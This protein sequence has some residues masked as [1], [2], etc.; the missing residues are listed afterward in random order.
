MIY[1][2]SDAHL[3]SRVIAQHDE[4]IDRLARLL[5]QL[6]N[7]ATHIFLLGDIFDFWYEY[8][9]EPHSWQQADES[10]CLPRGKRMFLPVIKALKELTTNGVEVHFFIGNHDIWTFGDLERNTGIHLHRSP[11]T[12]KLQG[13]TVYMAHGDGIVPTG[14]MEQ[15]PPALQ[16]KIRRFMR[17]RALFHHPV[18]QHLFRLLPPAL[19]DAFGYEWARRSRLKELRRPC[20]F[21]GETNEELLLW[22][23]EHPEYDYCI[24]GHRHIELDWQLDERRR[25]LILGD[26]FRQFTY[27]AMQN[28]DIRIHHHSPDL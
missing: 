11:A 24:F 8:L 18:A 15:L 26:F 16:T 10:W 4:H 17:L 21:K 19:G 12:F 3:G 27:A 13:K 2:L 14:Y 20:P 6:A 25:V 7:D 1:F 22:A 5:R 9:W 23:K 28:G